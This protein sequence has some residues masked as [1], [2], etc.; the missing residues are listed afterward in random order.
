[1]TLSPRLFSTSLTQGASQT[2]ASRP[3]TQTATVAAPILVVGPQ[4]EPFAGTRQAVILLTP[5]ARAALRSQASAGAAQGVTRPVLDGAVAFATR[6]VSGSAQLADPA[7][8]YAVA[9]ALLYG[10]GARARGDTMMEMS[11]VSMIQLQSLMS[12]RAGV[13]AMVNGLM[14]ALSESIRKVAGNIR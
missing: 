8:K 3:L 4:E 6:L 14:S 9:Y 1:M 10:L 13:I 11:E 2:L 5:G 7:S 12:Q